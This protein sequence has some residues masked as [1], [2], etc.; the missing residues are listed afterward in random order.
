MASND[1]ELHALSSDS[2]DLRPITNKHGVGET[3]TSPRSSITAREPQITRMRTTSWPVF[4]FV[5]Y[6]TFALFPWICLCILSKRPITKEK[7]YISVDTSSSQPEHWYHVSE[8]YFKV[9]HILQ[10]IATLVTIPVTTAICSMACV[11]YMQSSPLRRSLTLR[12][13]MALADSGWLSPH[14]LAKLGTTGSLPL[15]TAFALALFGSASQ[16]LQTAMV[17]QVEILASSGSH[18]SYAYVIDPLDYISDEDDAAGSRYRNSYEQRTLSLRSL[19]ELPFT[20]NDDINNWGTPPDSLYADDTARTDRSSA[21]GHIYV[22]LVNNFSSGAF[23]FRQFAPRMNSSIM[24]EEISSNDFGEN[25]RNE[26]ENGHFYARYYYVEQHAYDDN[27]YNPDVDFE[28]CVTNDLRISPWN[29][30]R[31]RQDLVEEMYYKTQDRN[32]G[33][34]GYWK[35]TSITSLG[36]FEVPSSQNGDVPGPLLEKDPFID[37]KVQISENRNAHYKE[38]HLRRRRDNVTYSG[39][40]TMLMSGYNKGP[41]TSVAIALFGPNSFVETRMSNPSNFVIPED[42]DCGLRYC[43]TGRNLHSCIHNAPLYDFLGRSR[44]CIDIYDSGSV[45]KVIGQVSTLLFYFTARQQSSILP[46]LSHALY[47]ANKLWLHQP[48]A[49]YNTQ[50]QLRIYY[51]EGIPTTKPELSNTG[52]I[53]GSFF[54]GLHLL[55]LLLLALYVARM[56]PW[57]SKMGSEV[58]LKMGMVYSDELARSET[59]QQWDRMVTTLPGFIGD[60]RPVEE[61]GRMRLGAAAGLSRKRDRKFEILR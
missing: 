3:S 19:L 32:K 9:A 49:G 54:L 28:V 8:K 33:S 51:D 22:P 13:S 52:I 56:K 16:I 21:A 58:M 26:T 24:S 18:P 20:S 17:G 44:N 35:I 25:C 59:K 36:Y 43:T 42:P 15:Y 14:V 30:T 10:S 48:I 40:A 38:T 47:M 34:L 4:V 57:S 6:A 2:Q 11:V 61:I 39:N 12:Q 55:G 50:G 5:I 37:D 41:L 46:A 29:I 23:P 1:M 60:E 53:V 31:D 45:N 7:A 27:Y